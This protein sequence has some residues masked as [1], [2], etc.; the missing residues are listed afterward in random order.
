MDNNVQQALSVYRDNLRRQNALGLAFFLNSWDSETEAPA[1]TIEHRDAQVGTLSEMYYELA[2]AADLTDAIRTL[3]TAREQLDAVLRHEI[4]VQYKELCK[5]QKVPQPEYVAFSQL[6]SK[7]TPV[8][9][10]AKRNAD[11]A[12]FCPYLEQIADYKKRYLEWQ[13]TP[14][15]HGYDILL[16]E[17]EPNTSV[18]FYD[19]LFDLL[20]KELVPLVHRIAAKGNPDFAWA[21]QIFPVDK[22]KQYVEYLRGVMCFDP[23][24][25]VIKESEHPFTGGN[26]RWDVRITNHYYPD[27]VASSIFSA[28]HEMGHGLYEMQVDQALD[29]TA[30]GG[31]ASMAMH[32]SQSRLMENMIGRSLAFWQTHYPQLQELFAP[33]LRNVT[34]NEWWR[35]VNR[36]QCSLVR[37]EADE[38]TYPLHVLIRYELEKQLL[39]GT[40]AVC[41]LPQAWRQ[42]YR[43]YLGV[44]VPDDRAGVL[45]DVHWSGGDFGY[46]P[47]YVLG[48]AYAAQLYDAMS[49]DLDIDAAI[50]EGTVRQLAQWLETH[51]HRYGASQ[52]PRDILQA[53]TGRDFDPSY[54]VNYLKDKYSALYGLD[55]D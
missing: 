21:R 44:D 22:Q 15:K 33:Q 43:E 49:K 28:I 27:D 32:E 16:D 23:A 52:Y 14:D 39:D 18:V 38:L 31:G 5:L 4:E 25:T 13:R 12:M 20:K 47:T 41:D 9:V 8:Y 54:Y 26:G 45:Q 1:L 10:E 35:Y 11:F 2:T 6:L 46:F 37:T 40:L 24:R 19:E 55:K 48:S 42:K 53:A 34:V 30:S 17:F 29:D 50:R 36:V 3:Y 7:A 51:V